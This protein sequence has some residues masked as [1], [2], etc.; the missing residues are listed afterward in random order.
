MTRLYEAAKQ[1]KGLTTQSEVAR[2]FNLSS[3]TVNNWETRGIS[4]GGLLRAQQQ[5]G[6]SATW[7]EFGEGAMQFAGHAEESGANADSPFITADS[8]L[9]AHTSVRAGVQPGAVPVRRVKLKVRA[10]VAGFEAEPESGDGGYLHIPPSDMKLI[11]ASPRDLLAIK[12][13]GDSMEPMM[14]ED[15]WVVVDTSDVDPKNKEVYA[16]NF[17]GEVIIKQLKYRN[18]EWYLHSLNSEHD[19][20]NARSK[21]CVI[22]GRFVYQPGRV[23][24]GRL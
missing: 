14:F 21:P 3:Q 13:V 10:G 17:A 7:L 11:D 18:R 2:F 19:T 20:V 16:L 23:V 6:C 15:D 24:K 5:L 12:V 22:I 1:L 4:R 8:A 9:G